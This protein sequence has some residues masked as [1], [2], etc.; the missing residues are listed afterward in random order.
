MVP[1]LVSMLFSI[2]IAEKIGFER[3]VRVSCL[4]FILGIGMC[5]FVTKC[6]YF[7]VCFFGISGTSYGISAIPALNCM[8]SHYSKKS[9][10]KVSGIVFFFFSVSGLLFTFIIYKIMNPNNQPGTIN[11]REKQSGD[12][13]HLFGEEISSKL[14]K[15][16]VVLTSVIAACML[17][18]GMLITK[19]RQPAE[20]EEEETAL[21]QELLEKKQPA[22]Q[23]HPT[24]ENGERSAGMLLASDAEKQDLCAMEKEGIAERKAPLSGEQHFQNLTFRRALFSKPFLSLF[25][26][27]FIIS[28]YNSLLSFNQKIYGMKKIGDDK[29]LTYI[30]G[31]NIVLNSA[32]SIP[33]GIAADKYSL[34][35]LYSITILT[36]AFFSASFPYFSNFKLTF[37]IWICMIGILYSGIITLA[38]PAL[39][40][41]FGVTQ[42]S[43]LV[44]IK[45]LSIVLALYTMPIIVYIIMNVSSY[46]FMLSLTGLSCLT[47]LILS[48]TFQKRYIW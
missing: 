5:A 35:F 13:L 6:E 46:D 4:T 42:G 15:T 34:R 38:A 45:S 26:I 14:P 18:G 30:N 7:I 27:T 2:K 31:L 28:V 25:Y 23:E 44:P 20:P 24:F 3:L 47:G 19:R 40:Q 21:G 1:L 17:A 9:T 32:A 39:I 8:W 22:G 33:W 11:Y 29:L 37:A 43:Q 48:L 12:T 16:M 36:F 10:G 41:F